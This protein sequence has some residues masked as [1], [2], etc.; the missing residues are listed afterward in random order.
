[1]KL[2]EH[3]FCLKLNPV[4]SSKVRKLIPTCNC[5]MMSPRSLKE[6]NDMLLLDIVMDKNNFDL[7]DRSVPL[8]NEDAI[9][10]IG[11]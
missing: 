9:Y 6:M 5:F 1:M 4:P 7:K 2:S 10:V 8:V 3:A 11:M